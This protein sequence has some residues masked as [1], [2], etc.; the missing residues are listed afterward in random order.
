MTILRRTSATAAVVVVTVLLGAASALTASPLVLQDAAKSA[1]ERTVWSGVYTVAQAARGMAKYD[2][3]C[4]SCHGTGEAPTLTGDAFMRRWFGDS[5]GAVLTKMRS[6]P[7][8]APGSLEDAEYVDIIAYVMQSTGFPA[9][10]KELPSDPPL[11]ATIRVVEKDGSAATVPNFSLVQVI[12][13]LTQGADSAWILV[14]GTEP[15]RSRESGDSDPAA[16]NLSRT[17]PL[18]SQAFRLLDY[19]I[20]GRETYARHKVQ[21]KGFLIRE[22]DNQKLNVTSVQSL[23]ETCAS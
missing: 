9:G 18:G 5:L 19:P 17:T 11:L 21:V 4:S 14:N 3:E 23:G 13:C 6:M 10:S 2:N 20:L 15:V 8:D 7:A 12:G 22:T 16:L 1:L